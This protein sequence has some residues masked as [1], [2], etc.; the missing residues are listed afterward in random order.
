[1]KP[2][3]QY[4]ALGAAALIVDAVPTAETAYN[5]ILDAMDVVFEQLTYNE[6]IEVNQ[7][8]W[9]LRNTAEAT[10]LLSVE[11]KL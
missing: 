3:D 6:R 10:K 11:V 1:M 7:R 9:A 2:V 5:A 4:M 8:Q